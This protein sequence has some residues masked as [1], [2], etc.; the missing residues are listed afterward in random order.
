M[1]GKRVFSI[2]EEWLYF[3]IY[4]RSYFADKIIIKISDFLSDKIETGKI[5]K[6]FFI[7][8]YDPDFHIRVRL[9]VPNPNDISMIIQEINALLEVEMNK[10]ILQI[11][12][13][14]YIREI[15]R[16]DPKCIELMEKLFFYDTVT[17]IP[18]LRKIEE[19]ELSED[20]RWLYGVV[21][22]DRTL[23]NFGLNLSEK[24]TFVSNINSSFS[25]EF[26]K[27]KTLNK[28]LDKTYREYEN[29]IT[30]NMNDTVFFSEVLSKEAENKIR[31]ISEILS[32]DRKKELT[33]Q[34]TIP[35]SGNLISKWPRKI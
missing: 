26:K 4:L 32:K 1:E 24:L 21:A 8:Y 3:K 23:A 11:S 28:Q 5:V 12:L 17:V 2:G 13:D 31:T 27:D 14:A 20:D 33:L 29:L 18:L 16:Y 34:S 9:F 25:L 15:E 30:E 10:R 7:R 22:L 35:K 6:W 19:G